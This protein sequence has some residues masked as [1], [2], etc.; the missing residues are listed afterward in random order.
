MCVYFFLFLCLC[1]GKS[2][3]FV[4]NELE[5]LFFVEI[6]YCAK[7]RLDVISENPDGIYSST[8]LWSNTRP[9]FLVGI[10]RR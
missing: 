4:L 5:F 6:I 2:A 8:G 9:L 3:I 7:K 10:V 1:D